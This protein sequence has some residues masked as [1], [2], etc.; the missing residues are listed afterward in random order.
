MNYLFLCNQGE[1]RSPAA[2]SVADLIAKDYDLNINTQ[3]AGFDSDRLNI[4]SLI[5]KSD[6]II[7]MENHIEHE[8]RTKFNCP[9]QIIVLHIPNIYKFEDPKLMRLLRKKL[10][11]IIVNSP[12]NK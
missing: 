1:I 3:F 5:D 8:L 10:Y 11:P 6:R 7:A 4:P 2:K 9:K 12:Y